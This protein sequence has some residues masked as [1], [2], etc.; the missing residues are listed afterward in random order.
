MDWRQALSSLL[1]LLYFSHISLWDMS[2][3]WPSLYFGL[4]SSEV[5]LLLF[6]ASLSRGLTQLHLSFKSWTDDWN[7]PGTSLHVVQGQHWFLSWPQAE[8]QWGAKV[9]FHVV[10]RQIH[11]QRHRLGTPVGFCLYLLSLSPVEN[12]VEMKI[13]LQ[14]SSRWDG[15]FNY[16]HTH[17]DTHADTTTHIDFLEPK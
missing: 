17:T 7:P 9:F 3:L 10:I 2:G 12:S 16:T 14:M 5:N 6:F 4:S 13:C 8:P 1:K 15:T 11:R